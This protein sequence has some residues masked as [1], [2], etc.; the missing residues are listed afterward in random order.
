MSATVGNS[1]G[2]HSGREMTKEGKE[3]MGE[4]NTQIDNFEWQDIDAALPLFT[5]GAELIKEENAVMAATQMD[6]LQQGGVR[7]VVGG[8]GI[9]QENTN[10]ANQEARGYLDE[11]RIRRAYTKLGMQERRQ[12]DELQGYG[13]MLNVGMAMKYQGKATQSAALNSQ[14]EHFQDMWGTFG[15]TGGAGGGS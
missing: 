15:G 13:Q 8:S 5:E 1:V 11:Q 14:S 12:V 6:A 4:A 9:I 2:F 10:K 3:M 7:G